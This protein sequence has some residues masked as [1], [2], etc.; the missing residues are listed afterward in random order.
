MQTARA[1][2]STS[3]SI[4][5]PQR[6]RFLL[7]RSCAY[8]LVD[9][10]E[11]ELGYNASTS[12]KYCTVHPRRQL[13]LHIETSLLWG[14]ILQKPIHHAPGPLHVARAAAPPGQGCLAGYL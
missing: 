10:M 4:T 8:H 7:V 2:K 13:Y 3:A 9:M 14:K 12:G 11:E 1:R 5:T 6:L